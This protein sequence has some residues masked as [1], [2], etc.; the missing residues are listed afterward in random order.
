GGGGSGSTGTSGGKSGS[1]GG[2]GGGTGSGG[3]TGGRT[4]NSGNSGGGG[5]SSTAGLGAVAQAAG[6]VAAGGSG[7]V[8]RGGMDLTNGGKF[9]IKSVY[10]LVG[11]QVT[12][13]IDG[14]NK[15][16]VSPWVDDPN[17][18]ETYLPELLD[19]LSTNGSDQFIEGRINVNQ[20]HKEVLL[21]LPGMTEDVAIKIVSAQARG[22]NGEPLPDTDGKRSNT[23]WLYAESIVDLPTLRKLNPYLTGRGDVFRLQVM[24]HFDGGGP[25]AR[26]EAVIDATQNP[27]QAI[28]FRDLTDL[29]RGYTLPVISR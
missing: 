3:G 13:K 16:L 1:G 11:V 4:G 20:A 9:K 26:V 19:L 15:T 12:G 18:M 29:G 24:G 22:A 7:Q 14:T 27:P 6:Q 21:G 10:D 5:G 8:T 17:Q 23:L 25:V 2:T 28:F